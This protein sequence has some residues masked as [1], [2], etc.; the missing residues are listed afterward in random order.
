MQFTAFYIQLDQI[1]VLYQGERT[2][3]RRFRAAMQDYRAISGAAHTSI[4]N[5]D[6]IGDTGF[7]KLRWQ[8]HITNLCHPGITARAAIFEHQNRVLVNLQRR[9][10]NALMIMFD[11]V[12]HDRSP[13][14]LEQTWTSC[15]RFQHSPVWRQVAA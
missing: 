12:E 7:Q 4:G 6:H 1:A 10:V 15:G 5:P 9:V 8:A 3:Y 14:V 13:R 2:S 11:V